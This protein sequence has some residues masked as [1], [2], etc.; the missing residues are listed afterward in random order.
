MSGLIKLFHLIAIV[1]YFYGLYYYVTF[2]S[3]PE[4]V[5]RDYEFGG[6][7]V[8]LTYLSFVSVHL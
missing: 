3:G 5:H 7:F 8:Y 6:L 1:H 2:V 4:I